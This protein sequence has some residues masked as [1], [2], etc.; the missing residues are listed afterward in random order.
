MVSRFVQIQN[1]VT[2]FPKFCHESCP[3]N[4]VRTIVNDREREKRA[5]RKTASKS[6]VE[7]Q[8]KRSHV[9]VNTRPDTPF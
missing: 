3:Y 9:E 4:V 2:T 8:K 5:S 1:S 7:E 6:R